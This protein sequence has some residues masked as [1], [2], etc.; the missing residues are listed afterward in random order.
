MGDGILCL[1]DGHHHVVIFGKWTNSAKT[2]YL[3]YVE[4]NPT[5]GTVS[6]S[7]PYP[8]YAWSCKP[9]RPHTIC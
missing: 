3:V 8:Y 2:E 7:I 4:A 1:S 6:H 9:I 5:T